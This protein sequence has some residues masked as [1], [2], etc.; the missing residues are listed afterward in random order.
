MDKSIQKLAW[1]KGYS[2]NLLFNNQYFYVDCIDDNTTTTYH[3]Y[4][5]KYNKTGFSISIKQK[6]II[7]KCP[8]NAGYTPYIYILSNECIISDKLSSI[9][10]NYRLEVNEDLIPEFICYGTLVAPAT[11]IK[12]F[13]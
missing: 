1:M 12:I 13:L 7:I 2:I 11:L 8:F 9:S 3:Y 4:P 10:D 6:R 5:N